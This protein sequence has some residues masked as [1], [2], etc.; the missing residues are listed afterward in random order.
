[1]PFVQEF[2]HSSQLRLDVVRVLCDNNNNNNN[3]ELSFKKCK[4]E[5]FDLILPANAPKRTCF[6]EI[7]S[8]IEFQRTECFELLNV[9]RQNQKS[10]KI[11]N[12]NNN[13]NNNN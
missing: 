2:T 11:N 7:G 8:K 13:N 1:V 5:E 12:N 10:K 4:N 3:N 6:N 9:Q